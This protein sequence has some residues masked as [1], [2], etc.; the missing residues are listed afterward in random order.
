MA[1]DGEEHQNKRSLTASAEGSVSKKA[2]ALSASPSCLVSG[3]IL[4]EESEGEVAQGGRGVVAEQANPPMAL[5]RINV[6]L[7]PQL[8]HCAATDCYRPLKPPV[9]KCVAGHRL[10]NNCRGDGRA[11][12]CR[13]CGRD[14]YFVHCGPDLDVY[15]GGFRVACPFRDYGCDS[16]VTYHESD[17]HRDACALCPF[18]ASPP[19]LHDHLAAD[20]AWPLHAVPSYGKLLHLYVAVSEPPHRLLVVEG[21]ERRLFVL[22]VRAR[23]KDIWAVSLACVRASAKAEPRYTYTLWA[24]APPLPDMPANM[25]RW[26][27]METDVPTCAVPG[28]GGGAAVEEEGMAL[29]VLPAMLVGPLK[30][31]H[32]RVRIDVVEP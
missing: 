29:C 7:Q 3:V 24:E 1:D 28:A 12:H 21:D 20:H 15:I 22:S 11:G 16:S 10:C 14:T 27:G 30:E 23:G 32:L 9:F 4:K 18:K 31:I 2:K 6:S 8:L 5:P 17:A 13:K 25:G 19:V 26:L